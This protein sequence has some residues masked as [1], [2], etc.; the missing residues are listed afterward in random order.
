MPNKAAIFIDG[1][2]LDHVLRDQFGGAQ[3]DYR[4]LSETLAGDA[5]MLC[6][7]YYHCPMYQSN[8]PTQDERDRYAAQRRFSQLLIGFRDMQS[9][10]GGWH[11]EARTRVGTPSLNKNG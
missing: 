3:I 11:I 9:G 1:V 10:S 4:L 8:P 6:T 7:Y 5:D 2:Y